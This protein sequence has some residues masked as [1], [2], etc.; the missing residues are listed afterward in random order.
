[1]GED[2]T[3]QLTS[4]AWAM[5][6]PRPLPGGHAAVRKVS[7]GL[8]SFSRDC[9]GRASAGDTGQ[10][11]LFLREGRQSHVELCASLS[12]CVKLASQPDCVGATGRGAGLAGPLGEAFLQLRDPVSLG[13]VRN[14]EENVG[15]I[16]CGYSINHI[17]LLFLP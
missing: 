10:E 15:F 6:Q 7:A 3:A 11:K 9:G 5:E 1:M 12:S 4:R 8:P 14:E 13:R 16:S 2:G 17:C